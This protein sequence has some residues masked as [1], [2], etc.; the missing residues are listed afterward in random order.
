MYSTRALTFFLFLEENMNI[1]AGLKY[2]QSDEWVKV[3]GKIAT[4]GVTD[5]AQDFTLRRGLL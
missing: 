3:E 2:T 1:P 4:I 5:Y